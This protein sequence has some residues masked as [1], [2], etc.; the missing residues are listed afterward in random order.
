MSEA[1]ADS[2]QS[3]APGLRTVAGM[4][5]RLHR[6]RRFSSLPDCYADFLLAAKNVFPASGAGRDQRAVVRSPGLAC[7][8][9]LH[10]E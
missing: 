3:V 7:S 2:E 1:D 5:Q 8:Q 4:A 10:R 9:P 6:S